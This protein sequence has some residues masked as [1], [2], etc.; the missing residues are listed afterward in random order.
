MLKKELLEL[1]LLQMLGAGDKY[2]YEMLAPLRG[3]FPDT[4]ESAIY[5]QLRSLCRDGYTKW[6]MAPGDGGPDRK[7]YTITPTGHARLKELL[8]AWQCL[9]K[10]VENDM[11]R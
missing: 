5:A 11:R 8:E 3:A 1:C 6:Y 4:H 7:Y 10:A 2:G 9:R